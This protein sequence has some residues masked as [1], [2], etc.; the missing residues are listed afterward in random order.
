MIVYKV[1]EGENLA[2]IAK[3]FSVDLGELMNKNKLEEVR[4]G[5]RV[6]IPEYKG[7]PYTVQP[8]DTLDSIAEKFCVEKADIINNNNINKVF[9]G[10]RLFIPEKK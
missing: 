4:S 6:V 5:M 7:I 9:L 1:K 10:L 8:Y 3:K 2:D